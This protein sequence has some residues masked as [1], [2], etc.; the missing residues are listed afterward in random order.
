[1][2]VDFLDGQSPFRIA[3]AVPAQV[4][5][6]TIIVTSENLGGSGGAG[7]FTTLTTSGTLTVGGTSTLAGNVT[8]SA[9]LTVTDLLTAS[10]GITAGAGGTTS[11]GSDLF[12]VGNALSISN[13]S[14]S[15]SM[16]LPTHANNAA[17]VAA[18]LVVTNLY[19]TSAGE[20]RIVV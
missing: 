4:V 2:S 19:K 11:I 13:L 15:I 5:G 1:M 20:L 3:L 6:S 10:G 8:A 17:A 16:V 14:G 7:S 9:R 12:A 18:G